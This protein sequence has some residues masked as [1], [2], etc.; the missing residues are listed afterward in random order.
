MEKC[1]AWFEIWVSVPTVGFGI[2]RYRS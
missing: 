1:Y 2:Y